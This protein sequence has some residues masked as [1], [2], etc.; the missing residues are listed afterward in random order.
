MF[1][2]SINLKGASAYMNSPD[3]RPEFLRYYSAAS[4]R[5]YLKKRYTA[6]QAGD[7]AMQ[8]YENAC[9]FM[10]YLEHGETYFAQARSAPISLQPVLLFYGIVQLLKAC[11][12]SINPDYPDSSSVLAHGVTARK[13]KKQQY[14]FLLDEVKI[15]KM[16]LGP[17]MA[18][19]MFQIKDLSFE[20]F[21]MET[22]LREIPEMQEVFGKRSFSPLIFL[23]G[24]KYHISSNILDSFQMSSLRLGSFLSVRLRQNVSFLENA[25]HTEEL[26]LCLEAKPNPNSQAPIRYHSHN[27]EWQLS[28]QKESAAYLLPELLIHYLILYNLSMICR[29]ETEWWS[30]LLKMMPTEDYPSILSYLS[31]AKEKIP[32]LIEQWL[33]KEPGN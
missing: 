31:I 27:K 20:K 18:K 6:L 8:S 5:S 2:F 23:S 33:Q 19:Y 32:F 25:E 4:S 3:I 24:Q 1:D 15:Q 22:L 14:S 28:L 12:L 13:R 7:P 10:Y 21:S 17:Y 11:L 26:V 29:Y 30:E 16:G 9:P